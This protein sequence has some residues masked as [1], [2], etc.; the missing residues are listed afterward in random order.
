M[1]TEIKET[2]LKPWGEKMASLLQVAGGQ[3][4]VKNT[5]SK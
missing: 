3:W 4:F 5:V 2:K 1:M